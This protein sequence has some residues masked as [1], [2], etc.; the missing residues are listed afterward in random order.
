M[1]Y[2]R[3]IL[4]LND[5]QLEQF[6]HRWA[7]AKAA[8]NYVEVQVLGD[9][10]DKGRDVVGFLTDKRHE[11]PWDNFQCK[12]LGSNLG[13]A[14]ALLDIGKII[15]F[16]HQGAFS[17]PRRFT[18]V[19]PRGTARGLQDLI[20]NPSKLKNALTRDW[21][22][23]CR[24]KIVANQVIELEGELLE[25]F[26]KFDFS[27]VFIMT[28]DDLLADEAVRGVLVAYFAAEPPEPP[29][30]SMPSQVA[31]TELPYVNELVEAYGEREGR[32]YA[33]HLEVVSHPE[34]GV[35]FKEQR[36]RFYQADQ[37]SR[38]YRDNTLVEAMES[39][40]NEVYHGI[41]EK[42]RETHKDRLTRISAV[43]QQAASIAPSGV[44]ARYARVPVR[45]GICHL[46]VNDGKLTWKR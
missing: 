39:L 42:H 31:Q 10:G 25:H 45:Q 7:R 40:Q 44:L 43:M 19:A 18:F 22:K 34:H 17:L 2:S 35:H 28:L 13:T 15:Y 26:E 33:N 24:T 29:A 30:F 1:D 9:A 3:N 37:F 4:V 32:A 12:Q 21:N 5:K 27:N 23:Y 8:Y 14:T 20:Y 11:G 6:I 36:E 41:I 46:F 16:S 38:F